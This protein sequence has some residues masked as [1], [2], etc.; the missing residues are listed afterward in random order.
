VAYRVQEYNKDDVFNIRVKVMRL[1]STFRKTNKDYEEFKRVANANDMLKGIENISSI[2]DD[3]AYELAQILWLETAASTNDSEDQIFSFIEY[4][5]TIFVYELARGTGDDPKRK[6]LLGVIW[7]TATMRRNFKLFGDYISLV[8]ILFSQYHM[9]SR[10][11]AILWG[12]SHGVDVD[13]KVIVHGQC[14]NYYPEFGHD[15]SSN[16]RITHYMI[17]HPYNSG[18]PGPQHTHTAHRVSWSSSTIAIV[19]SINEYCRIN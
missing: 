7:Q 15:D 17:L 6:K 3:E 10:R 8:D 16:Q 13:I 4:L 5:E 9:S 2:D 12:L 1:M 14:R 11:C 19:V 18:E